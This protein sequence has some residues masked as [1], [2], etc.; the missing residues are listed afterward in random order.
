MAHH[1]SAGVESGQ[2][3]AR[4]SVPLRRNGGRKAGAYWPLRYLD[5]T[6]IR[7]NFLADTAYPSA[8]FLWLNTR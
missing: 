4:S 8:P 3:A 7:L 6:Y 5:R 2:V 1:A